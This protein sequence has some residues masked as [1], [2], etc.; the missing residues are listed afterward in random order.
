MPNTRPLDLR[1]AALAL[2]D[3][4]EPHE[5]GVRLV[6]GD[7]TALVM[8]CDPS[9]APHIRRLGAGAVMGGLFSLA[10]VALR[11]ALGGDVS[12]G[13]PR[14][15]NLRYQYEGWCEPLQVR[16]VPLDGTAEVAEVR[17][18]QRATGLVLAS[19]FVTWSGDGEIPPF[20]PPGVH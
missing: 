11:A 18:L 10:A 17:I 2:A 20:L 7:P 12:G 19:G 6:T 14:T 15:L 8:N 16:C 3:R 5:L 9:L 4:S 1:A 13:A